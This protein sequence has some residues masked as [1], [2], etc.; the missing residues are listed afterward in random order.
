MNFKQFLQADDRIG[1]G[2]SGVVGFNDEFEGH[3]DDEVLHASQPRRRS[4]IVFLAE[5][6]DELGR[7]FVAL[8]GSRHLLRVI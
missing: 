3:C 7:I 6:L 2:R 5:P 8:H 1:H 4:E